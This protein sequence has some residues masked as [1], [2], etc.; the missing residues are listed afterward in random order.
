MTLRVIIFKFASEAANTCLRMMC[1]A[2]GTVSFA[3]TVETLLY[4]LPLGNRHRLPPV[5]FWDLSSKFLS[6]INPGNFA[7]TNG[8]LGAYGQPSGALYCVAR[9]AG[10][11]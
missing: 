8:H 10:V 7:L 3:V 11:D 1:R 6:L 9:R 4:D 5:R 2:V